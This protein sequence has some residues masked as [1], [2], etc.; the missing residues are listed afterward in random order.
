MK[1]FKKLLTPKDLLIGL[2]QT[3]K[4]W[5]IAKNEYNKE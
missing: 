5:G 3:D 1:E 4:E 2:E